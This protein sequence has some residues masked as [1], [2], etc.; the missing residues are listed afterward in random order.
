MDYFTNANIINL[1]GIN[2]IILLF[3]VLLVV[4]GAR[5]IYVELTISKFKKLAIDECRK[6]FCIDTANASMKICRLVIKK[7]ILSGSYTELLCAAAIAESDIRKLLPNSESVSFEARL[8][9]ILETLSKAFPEPTRDAPR[10]LYKLVNNS[11]TNFNE[12]MNRRKKINTLNGLLSYLWNVYPNDLRFSDN[13]IK[14][15]DSIYEKL[16]EHFSQSPF[17][18]EQPITL[19][20]KCPGCEEQK[21]NSTTDGFF[22]V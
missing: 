13:F 18:Q 22:H 2:N 16:S 15:S 17:S 12:T 11:F 14:C 6:S 3:S 4:M 7:L 21:A 20:I 8:I 1:V 5:I 9:Q 10:E 19:P